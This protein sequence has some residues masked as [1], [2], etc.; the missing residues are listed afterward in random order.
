MGLIDGTITIPSNRTEWYAVFRVYYR[1]T[2]SANM[3]GSGY[4]SRLRGHCITR[5]LAVYS[6]NY[7]SKQT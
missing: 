5:S 1:T 2:T 7:V 4:D 6:V 3:T